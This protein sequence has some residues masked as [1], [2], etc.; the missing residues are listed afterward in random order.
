MIKKKQREYA[1]VE[2]YITPFLKRYRR[3]FWFDACLAFLYIPLLAYLLIKHPTGAMFHVGWTSIAHITTAGFGIVANTL[4]LR[5]S[6]QSTAFAYL[7]IIYS[8]F[9]RGVL[10]FI[11]A[12]ANGAIFIELIEAALPILLILFAYQGFYGWC[13]FLYS[14]WKKQLKESSVDQSIEPVVKTPVESGTVQ[15]SE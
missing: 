7:K 4:L 11:V 2:E 15:G 5:D 1:S 13:V 10:F 12:K 3:V 14:K 6:T 8:F 9:I